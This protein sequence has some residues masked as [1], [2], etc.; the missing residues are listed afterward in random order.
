MRLE[1]TGDLGDWDGAAKLALS[2]TGATSNPDGSMTFTVVIG[3]G[4]AT[5]AFLWIR[6]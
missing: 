3:D 6:R 2:V 1:V 5:R 4:T